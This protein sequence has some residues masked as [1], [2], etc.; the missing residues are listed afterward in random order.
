ML[1]KIIDKMKLPIKRSEDISLINVYLN[2]KKWTYVNIFSDKLSK[3]ISNKS[4]IEVF[5]L[6][7]TEIAD[8]CNKSKILRDNYEWLE[9]EQQYI[10]KK[11]NL[12]YSFNTKKD[13]QQITNKISSKKNKQEVIDMIKNMKERLNFPLS[14]SDGVSLI[15]I[16]LNDKQIVM[17]R[18]LLDGN[19]IK[20]LGKYLTTFI[21]TY[22]K[23][24]CSDKNRMVI[25]K[26]FVPFVV[27]EELVSI[28]GKKITEFTLNNCN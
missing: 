19:I 8:I 2:G 23:T 3:A 28:D 18:Y 27:G 10:D 15:D 7:K 26:Q 20:K 14:V 22:K 1:Q 16:Y 9:I 4:Q 17:Y 13:C 12:I 21:K 5:T 24:A 11:E 6:F 25:K